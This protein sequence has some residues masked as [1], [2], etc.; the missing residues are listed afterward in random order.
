[1][2]GI[3]SSLRPCTKSKEI[4]KVSQYP[5]SPK[6]RQAKKRLKVSKIKLHSFQNHK[7]SKYQRVQNNIDVGIYSLYNRYVYGP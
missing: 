3:F 6:S 4:A 7:F 1:M 5:T 2:Y